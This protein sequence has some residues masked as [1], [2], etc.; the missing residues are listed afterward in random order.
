GT[1][2]E[3]FNVKESQEH[4][5]IPTSSNFSKEGENQ[6]VLQ[7]LHS[8]NSDA[9]SIISDERTLPTNSTK[10]SKLISHVLQGPSGC[11]K[12]LTALKYAK[13]LV[14]NGEIFGWFVADS[15]TYVIT[16]YQRYADWAHKHVNSQILTL[17][18]DELLRK[19]TDPDLKTSS[20]EATYIF[21]HNVTNF[22]HVVSI[23]HAHT[24]IGTRILATSRIPV[25]EAETDEYEFIE[26]L[27]P[28]EAEWIDYLANY[29]TRSRKFTEEESIKLA[30]A[31]K[32]HP[33][34]IETAA[35]FLANNKTVSVDEYVFRMSPEFKQS[36]LVLLCLLTGLRLNAILLDTLFACIQSTK[37]TSLDT[38]LGKPLD[39]NTFND[40]I[41]ALQDMKLIQ[42]LRMVH[43]DRE[44]YNG[45]NEDIYNEKLE[46]EFETVAKAY[47]NMMNNVEMV[48]RQVKRG[49]AGV[50]A[51]FM[52]CMTLIDLGDVSLDDD[53]VR[54]ISQV[55]EKN[56][57]VKSLQMNCK[58]L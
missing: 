3:S 36:C 19:L 11:G 4:N 47:K 27:N 39:Q 31:A 43:I 51:A 9:R 42:G 50:V 46:E 49:Y 55:L 17:T 2:S 33:Q 18:L 1:A 52:E 28:T 14:T 22:E 53:D 5:S 58:L 56:K 41:A 7:S 15:E 45:M 23:A 24:G 44:Q 34:Q 20:R 48:W 21:L 40:L 30:R 54:I 6:I 25:Y 57:T 37:I 32:C 16:N 8:R 29:P 26:M 35:R 12:T 10:R 38:A 13:D